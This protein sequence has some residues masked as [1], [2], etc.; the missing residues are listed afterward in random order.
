MRLNTAA[1]GSDS[2]SLL[3]LT[4]VTKEMAS[5]TS[6]QPTLTGIMNWS[7][8]GNR[9]GKRRQEVG[10][11]K[12]NKEVRAGKERALDDRGRAISMPKKKRG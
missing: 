6:S 2:Q 11:K 3:E 9:L 8:G 5:P 7:P 12:E 1:E 10:K 4:A